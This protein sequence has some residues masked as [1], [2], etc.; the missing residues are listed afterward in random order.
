MQCGG[1]RRKEEEGRAHHTGERRSKRHK[2]R[3]PT[4]CVVHVPMLE[5]RRVAAVGFFAARSMSTVV[6]CSR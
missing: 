6:W 4:A 2:Q 3:R 1:E 5:A